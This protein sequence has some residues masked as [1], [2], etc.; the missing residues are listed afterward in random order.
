[1]SSLKQAI[2]NYCQVNY[3][4]EFEE[5]KFIPVQC[6][7][8]KGGKKNAGLNFQSGV[9]NC[10]R[11]CGS[12]SFLK[13]AEKL[14]IDYNN[15][16][17][18]NEWEEL[19]E[20]I[21]PAKRRTFTAKKQVEELA[22]F[23]EEKSLLPETIERWG[24][25]LILDK[26]DKLYGYLRFPLEGN[27]YCARKI[28]D[29][30]VGLGKGERFYNKGTRTLLGLENLKSFESLILAEGITDFL[31]LYQMG[32]GNVV[33]CMGSKL[34]EE[35]AYLLRNKTVFI[36]FDRDFAGYSGALKAQVLLK[37][38]HCNAIIIE[39]PELNPVKTDINLFYKEDKE[40]LRKFIVKE[41][42]RYNQFDNK[43]VEGLKNGSEPLKYYKTGLSELDR[44]LQ[45]GYTTGVY[46]Y[47]GDTGIGKSTIVSSQIPSL[48]E[49]GAN[50]LW[51]TYE[52]SK[53]QCWARI[54]SK[55]S[56]KTFV[57][58]EKSFDT[59]EPSVYENYILPISN[60]LRIDSLPTIQQIEAS[61]R[62]F[63]IIIIDY[64]QRMVAPI[65]VNDSNQAVV[66]NNAE[67][68]RLMQDYGKTIILISSMSNDGSLIKG[69]GDPRYTS[70]ASFLASKIGKDMMS[71]KIIKNT[72][73]EEGHT[74][75]LKSNYPHQSI[76]QAE[77]PGEF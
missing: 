16:E 64:L 20:S 32:Y 50:V 3:Q 29:K 43:Y 11:G 56:D 47:S 12:L 51:C 52:L 62:K 13:L 73:G 26:E 68:S 4:K 54:G 35:Q 5:D 75:F 67:I 6:P 25:E 66:K 21:I 30:A 42:T 31:T 2:A 61:I 59:I 18:D 9:F 1:M 49:Q 28:I 77:N 72:R 76:T 23:Y 38:Y 70:Q 65:G 39:L 24:G 7:L 34:S 41:T 15:E 57:E 44:Y 71:L 19:L 48:I 36:I 37:Q 55:V 14:G 69:S 33:C 22:N 40:R 10:F 58:L 46:T 8:H 63:D 74:I 60:H 27:A 17:K 45:G 53:L